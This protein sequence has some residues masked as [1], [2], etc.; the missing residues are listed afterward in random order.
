MELTKFPDFLKL[1]S[2]DLDFEFYRIAEVLFNEYQISAN[3]HYYDIVEIE[4]YYDSP[5]HTDLFIYKGTIKNLTTGNWFIHDSGIDLTF[6]DTDIKSRGGI[7]IRAIKK[8][9][10]QEGELPYV[11]GSW[12]TTKELLN[13]ILPVSEQG[14]LSLELVPK[15]PFRPVAL[16]IS[17]R[18]GLNRSKD[19]WDSN[20]RFIADIE[21]IKSTIQPSV[22]KNYYGN[23]DPQ[24]K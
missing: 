23:A 14:K 4:F 7:L 21:K 1:S 9:E 12:R 10:I 19:G 15:S 18:V 3:E 6:G 20:F 17:K 8:L 16:T 2:D 22:F 13:R 11:I 24:F 5:K